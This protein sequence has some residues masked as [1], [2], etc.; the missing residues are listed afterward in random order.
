MSG[1]SGRAPGGRIAVSVVSQSPVLVF[2]CGNQKFEWDFHFDPPRRNDRLHLGDSL[3]R[4]GK[5]PRQRG[6]DVTFTFDVLHGRFTVEGEGELSR[7]K[8]VFNLRAGTLQIGIA[9]DKP[10]LNQEVSIPQHPPVK[11]QV[12]RFTRPYFGKLRRIG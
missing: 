6:N 10:S 5:E 2:E 12:D 7:L 4:L 8:V 3:I 9:K 1:P 11:S